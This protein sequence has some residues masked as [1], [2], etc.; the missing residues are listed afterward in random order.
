MRYLLL[1]GGLFLLSCTAAKL[2]VPEPFKSAASSMKMKGV[3]GWMINQQLVFGDYQT[4][5]VKRGWD[6]SSGWQAT[7]LSF[8]PEQLLMKVFAFDADNKSVTEKNKM[9]FT[10]T[11]GRQQAVVYALEKFSEKQLV[12]RNRDPRWGEISSSQSVQY[13]F[14]AAILLVAEKTPEPWQLVLV[15]REDRKNGLEEEG[16]L[17]DGDVQFSIQPLRIGH[18][19]NAK[20]KDL[21]VVG[22]PLFAGY[23]IRVEDGVVAVVD[24]L[25]NQFWMLNDLDPDYQMVLATAVS[26]LVL[27]R[28]RDIQE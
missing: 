8:R 16:Y 7:N 20:G 12:F 14:S 24:L 17:T 27:K 13:A 11:N 21:K 9:Q 10:V 22:G 1:F 15:H 6:F 5:T 26:S 23:E 28:K 25:D 3:N 4:G 2:G 18:Y 19:T